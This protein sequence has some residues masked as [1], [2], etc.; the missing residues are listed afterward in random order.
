MGWHRS[1]MRKNSLF[2]MVSLRMMK[3]LQED[4]AHRARRVCMGTMIE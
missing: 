2:W 1:R 3:R 4:P